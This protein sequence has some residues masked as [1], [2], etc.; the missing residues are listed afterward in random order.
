MSML[1]RIAARKEQYVNRY[2]AF[3]VLKINTD[4][5]LVAQHCPELLL[6]QD[7]DLTSEVQLIDADDEFDEVK[8]LSIIS[9]GLS[10]DEADSSVAALG[11]TKPHDGT[12]G[13][14]KRSLLDE[15]KIEKLD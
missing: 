4:Q 14:M 10:S 12:D 11:Q 2:N 6:V 1:L 5:S 8:N 15:L 7:K 3:P 9:K 13:P